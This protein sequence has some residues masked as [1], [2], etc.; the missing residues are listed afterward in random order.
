VKQYIDAVQIDGRQ[1]QIDRIEIRQADG[2]RS[3]MQVT[4]TERPPSTSRDDG[5]RPRKLL[6][7]LVLVVLASWQPCARRSEPI[8]RCSCRA[9]ALEQ[10]IL[11]EQ[12]RSGALARL[13]LVA[14]E[15]GTAEMRGEARA[16]SPNPCAP[17]RNFR[18]SPT[19]MAHRCRQ[20]AR[21]CSSSATF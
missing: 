20:T 8:C 21:S 5:A 4:P 7:A 6:A 18:R 16:R 1:D 9:P 15:G 10:Q 19:A 17:T 2:V 11:I 3:V 13:V 12:L 14:I